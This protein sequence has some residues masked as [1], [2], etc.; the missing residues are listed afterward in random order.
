MEAHHQSYPED[1]LYAHHLG[2]SNDAS[3][4]RPLLARLI[5][6]AKQQL[7]EVYGYSL[8]VPQ[9]WWELVAKA[10]DA[11][12]SLGRWA[13]QN[14]HRW[15]W[16]LDGLDRLNPDDQNALPWLPLT[17][18]DG[19]LIVASA[20]ECPA[21][22]ILVKR[23]FKTLTIAPLQEA[24]QRDLIKQYLG[25]YAKQLVAELRIKI[26]NH[27]L[28]GSPLFLRV[29]LEELRQ[30]G[31]HETL[32]E[33]LDG[34][35]AV[36]TID[37]LYE[38]VLE[39]LELDGDSENVRKVMTALWASKA[40]LSEEELLSFTKLASLQW[41]PID[42]SLTEAIRRNGN[43]LL[44]DHDYLRKA[45]E[46]RYLTSKEDQQ[47][48]HN[49]LAHWFDSREEWDIRKMEELPWQLL[50]AFR[51]DFLLDIL[52]REQ[53]LL[54]LLRQLDPGVAYQYWV[55]ACRQ[56][57]KKRLIESAIQS[58]F[59][60][61]KAKSVAEQD[62]ETMLDLA[63]L[64]GLLTV[65]G[66][67]IGNL[68]LEICKHYLKING[69]NHEASL[70]VLA[71]KETLADCSIFDNQPFLYS[72][73]AACYREHHPDLTY[74]RLRVELKSAKKYATSGQYD[75]AND[76][77]KDAEAFLEADSP[78]IPPARIELNYILSNIYWQMFDE[79]AAIRPLRKSIKICDHYF[80]GES[81][82]KLDTLILLNAI[83]GDTDV[84]RAIKRS[85]EALELCRK[86]LGA[87]HPRCIGCLEAYTCDL[88]QKEK[89]GSAEEILRLKEFRYGKHSSEYLESYTSYGIYHIRQRKY[90]RAI[91]IL[92]DS[93]QL[94]CSLFGDEYEPT[95]AA[96]FNY[97]LVCL[98]LGKDV[99]GIKLFANA[100][101]M[102]VDT[103]QECLDVKDDKV[104]ERIDD[105]AIFYGSAFKGSHL[106]QRRT[107][108]RLITEA[109]KR[110]KQ[111]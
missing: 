19:V 88:P 28:A 104:I 61:I 8:Q 86:Y 58:I 67:G 22:E 46:N 54:S 96:A 55:Q 7:P 111:I 49:D 29:L 3:A 85:K 21:R 78:I 14:N 60:S 51:G 66:A 40:G 101:L 79:D 64:L 17:I 42:L 76:L 50:R 31:R 53:P 5:E 45:V 33:Q 10:A 39:R 87:D 62:S 27:P 4:I 1:F 2:C 37:D 80:G 77:C 105:L 84:N 106:D 100:L 41:A 24:E 32:A 69:G 38:I 43:R 97:S 91:A 94:H 44:F 47:Q 57:E 30:F 90:E 59:D 70:H 92:A 12:Q 11:L 103:L 6:T 52:S 74:R 73:L 81:L 89:V 82:A 34:Y 108:I 83:G 75:M 71:I 63:N 56:S 110:Q 15:I 18:P 93:Y 65:A 72:Q 23:S 9:D 16:V 98:S 20:L 99:K 68:A 48:A 36:D 35:L 109:M 13:Q 25:R 102:S 26:L 95:L 107:I